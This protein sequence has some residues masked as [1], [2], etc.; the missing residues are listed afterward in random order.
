MATALQALPFLLPHSGMKGGTESISVMRDMK[1]R[2]LVKWIL[3]PKGFS[4]Q[5]THAISVSAS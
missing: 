2:T 3:D 1:E 5:E 4:L